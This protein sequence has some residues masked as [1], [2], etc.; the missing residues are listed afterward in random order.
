MTT[1]AMQQ[2]DA[3]IS[4]EVARLDSQPRKLPRTIGVMIPA[5]PVSTDCHWYAVRAVADETGMQ[6]ERKFIERDLNPL[7]D[8]CGWFSHD[9]GAIYRAEFDHMLSNKD[10]DHVILRLRYMPDGTTA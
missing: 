10:C 7:G 8:L 1:K 6:I 9:S 5:G 2:L 3:A 4:A